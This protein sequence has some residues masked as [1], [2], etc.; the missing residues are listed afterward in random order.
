MPP[1]I[2]KYIQ[3]FFVQQE[4]CA[5]LPNGIRLLPAKETKLERKREGV[6]FRLTTFVRPSLSLWASE[7]KQN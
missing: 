4:V 7:D 3:R 1:K 6:R 5:L 2:A